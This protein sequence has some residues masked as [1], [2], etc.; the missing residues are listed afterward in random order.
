MTAVS[1]CTSALVNGQQQS[2]PSDTMH[3]CP[4]STVAIYISSVVMQS[5]MFVPD[6]I[7][8][9]VMHMPGICSSLFVSWLCLDSQSAMNSC[10]PGLY[11]I[12]RLH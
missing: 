5:G 10:G 2:T 12:F 11:S 3:M 9:M 1:F 8:L 7:M 6:S 4:S